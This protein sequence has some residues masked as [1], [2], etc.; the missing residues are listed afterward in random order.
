MSKKL[1]A[2]EWFLNELLKN[3]IVKIS[4]IDIDTYS[5]AKDMEKEQSENDYAEG[6]EI[7]YEEGLFVR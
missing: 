7:G 2:V 5:K 4:D 6:Y 1:T 3:N